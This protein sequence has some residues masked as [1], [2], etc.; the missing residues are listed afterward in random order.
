MGRLEILAQEADL[1]ALAARLE[2]VERDGSITARH[3]DTSLTALTARVGALE[4]AGAV[5]DALRASRRVM[6]A[7]LIAMAGW[8]SIIAGL[9]TYYAHFHT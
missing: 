4:T 8:G 2:V 3:A 6:V 9:L 7:M 5:A 1:R